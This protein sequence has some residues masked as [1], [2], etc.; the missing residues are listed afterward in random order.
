LLG[1]EDWLWRRRAR[2]PGAST[3]P[4]PRRRREVSSSGEPSPSVRRRAPATETAR[5]FRQGTFDPLACGSGRLPPPHRPLQVGNAGRPS[6]AWKGHPRSP[7]GPR[8]TERLAQMTRAALG[9]VPNFQDRP[10]PFKP[11][12]A[13]ISSPSPRRRV[14]GRQQG[15]RLAVRSQPRPVGVA[16]QFPCDAWYRRPASA[17]SSR[18]PLWSA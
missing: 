1:Q 17:W 2:A 12:R 15:T 7:I 5:P 14:E 8:I 9:S 18:S 16:H 13:P 3:L 10:S 6:R 4:T 11:F